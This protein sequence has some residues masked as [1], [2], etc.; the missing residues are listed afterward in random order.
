M[1]TTNWA[2]FDYCCYNTCI[3]NKLLSGITLHAAAKCFWILT[4]GCP[5]EHTSLLSPDNNPKLTFYFDWPET[6][7]SQ[8]E[9]LRCPCG[10]EDFDIGVV[11]N[12]TRFCGGTFNDLAEWSSPVDAACNFSVAARKLC[13]LA[14]VSLRYFIVTHYSNISGYY[15]SSLNLTSC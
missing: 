10:P 5:A 7:I 3:I 12:A 13:Q 1:V 4:E 9:T 14:F 6:D 8:M 15:C 2:W 11:R